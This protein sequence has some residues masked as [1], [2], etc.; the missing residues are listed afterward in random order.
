MT[1][2]FLSYRRHDSAYVAS[3]INEKLEQRFGTDSVFF[4]V[5]SIPLGT[6]FRKYI[7]EA[8]SM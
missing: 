5:D 4:D 1:R 6:D 7:S 3:A 2:I 8:M